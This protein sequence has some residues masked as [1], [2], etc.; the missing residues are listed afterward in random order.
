MSK[1]D[2][3]YSKKDQ[4]MYW[5]Y[6]ALLTKHKEYS[7]HLSKEFFYEEAS[8]P[9][10]ICPERAGK[11]IRQM[12]KNPPPVPMEKITLVVVDPYDMNLNEI[13]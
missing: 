4:Y 1:S 7:D 13:N 6:Q 11:L 8:K 9:F 5:Y 12:I 2:K 3:I 10:W